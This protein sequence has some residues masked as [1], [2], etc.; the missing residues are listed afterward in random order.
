MSMPH[1]TNKHVVGI[2]AQHE[3]KQMT[4]PAATRADRRAP[5]GAAR[6][7]I[8]GEDASVAIWR[9]GVRPG[10]LGHGRLGVACSEAGWC[11]QADEGHCRIF[12]GN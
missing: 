6:E 10:G 4:I 7:T 1:L 2:P 12:D 9:A 8:G 5:T 3:T 11:V